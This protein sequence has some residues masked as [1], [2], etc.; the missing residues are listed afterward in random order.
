MIIEI[1]KI[2]GT[3]FGC[4]VTVTLLMVCVDGRRTDRRQ[5]TSMTTLTRDTQRSAT[6]AGDVHLDRRPIKS[7]LTVTP[8]ADGSPCSGFSS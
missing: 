2:V 3:G 8:G 6:P 4:L 7:R 5:T 1:I